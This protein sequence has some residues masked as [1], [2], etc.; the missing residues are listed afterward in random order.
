MDVSEYRQQVEQE[1][2][3]AAQEQV[4]Y[5]A[6]LAQTK[7]ASGI[8]SLDAESADPL[9]QMVN[10]VRDQNEALENRVSA[11]HMISADVGESHDLLDVVLDIL[12][13]ESEPH[14][15]RM[16]AFSVL[17]Q[18]SFS[19]PT[20]FIAKRPDYLE[21]LRGLVEDKDTEV[22]HRAI[23]ILSLEKDEYVQRRLLDQLEGKATRVVG[24]AKAIQLLGNDIHAEHYPLLREIVQNPPSRAAKKEAVRLLSSDPSSQELLVDILRDKDEHREVRKLSA[25]ALQTLAPEAFA[26]HAREIV[27]DD[28]EYDEIRTTSINALSQFA[29]PEALSQDTDLSHQVEAL[30]EATSSK[31]L[32]K[33][34]E[35]FL[36]TVSE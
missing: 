36:E 14:E 16:A 33:A 34:S 27:L 19:S 26:Q 2:A 5:E 12:R 4:T 32:T 9:A 7:P 18:L 11:L 6:F 28:D 31:Q 29:D 21:T 35:S 22:R 20:L 17:D 24:T 13:D 15:L 3:Q 1:L 30:K 8:E 25:V 10:I 23:E